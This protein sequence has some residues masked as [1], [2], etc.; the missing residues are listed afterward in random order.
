M[1]SE[2][3]YIDSYRLGARLGS[4]A[5]G[6]VYLAQHIIL[7]DRLVAIKLMHATYLDSSEAIIRFFAEAQI[8]DKLKHP[9]ILPI[10]NVSAYGVLP[11]LVTEYASKGSL[12]DR[13]KRQYPHLL[14]VEESI[15]ILAQIGQAL[16]HAHQYNIIHRDLKPENIL[17]NDKGDT[18]LADFGIATILT[19]ASVKQSRI[20]GT[21]LYM[22]PEQFRG[23]ISRESDQYAL[24]C[25]AY[26]LFTGSKPFTA[27]D[28]V[29]L[30]FKHVTDPP[31]APRQ[32]NQQLSLHI[33]Q[34]IP[35]AMA[36]E[37][38]DRH[39]DI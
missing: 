37:R 22:A 27:P 25:I 5:F 4:G 39:T 11:Y 28:F 21:P 31:I 18:L 33:Y 29:A 3:I 7:T 20:I 32:I 19:T 6:D 38:A 12:R 30:M 10:I 9:H 2:E 1:E 14:P 16:Q 17:F 34:A 26:E 13:L 8:L 24:G 23:I 35:K 15:A 36:K